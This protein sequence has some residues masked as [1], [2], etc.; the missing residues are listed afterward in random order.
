V[1]G[2]SKSSPS[3]NRFARWWHETFDD[4]LFRSMIGP[5]QVENA[6]HGC[7]SAAREQWKRDLERRK[8]YTRDQRERR[9]AAS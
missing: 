8:Q 3:R 9:R 7:D 2:V 1:S 6:V 4:W 5:A